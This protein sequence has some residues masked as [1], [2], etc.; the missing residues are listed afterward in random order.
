MDKSGEPLQTTPIVCSRLYVPLLQALHALG[1]WQE[2]CLVAKGNRM[3]ADE[4]VQ[5]LRSA[6]RLLLVSKRTLTVCC[7]RLG[8]PNVRVAFA[9]PTLKKK[10]KRLAP[11]ELAERTCELVRVV[12]PVA[13]EQTNNRSNKPHATNAESQQ[14]PCKVIEK[15][16][17]H[18]SLSSSTLRSRMSKQAKTDGQTK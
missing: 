10:R 9:S 5:I 16:L 15:R 7:D 18:S 8:S 4:L 14:Q 11:T 1:Q 6:V 12:T 17:L 13:A 2:L 3:G